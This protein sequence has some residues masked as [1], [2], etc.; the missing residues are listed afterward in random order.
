MIY[1][2]DIDKD[3]YLKY[4]LMFKDSIQYIENRCCWKISKDCD[5]E[6]CLIDAYRGT[7]ERHKF[8]DLISEASGSL[9]DSIFIANYSNIFSDIDSEDE[10]LDI[11]FAEVYRVGSVGLFFNEIMQSTI[12]PLNRFKP[13]RGME[14]YTYLDFRSLSYK[15]E[16]F[17]KFSDDKFYI[18]GFNKTCDR[19][20]IAHIDLDTDNTFKISDSSYLWCFQGKEYVKR[21]S[22]DKSCCGLTNEIIN[23]DKAFEFLG[24][25]RGYL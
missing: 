23:C 9:V 25:N 17:L 3:L 16:K 10:I 13:Y 19:L 7:Q 12:R 8:C 21:I 4:R 15:G 24:F 2:G 5:I 20:V 11:N 22:L 6:V 1:I 14:D 18:A